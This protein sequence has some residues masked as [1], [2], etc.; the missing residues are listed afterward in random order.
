MLGIPVE[1]KAVETSPQATWI[2][3]LKPRP[4]SH[5]PVFG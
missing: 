1:W 4:K 2:V 3:G 5:E